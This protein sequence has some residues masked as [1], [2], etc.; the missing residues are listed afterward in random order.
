VT[1]GNVKGGNVNMGGEKGGKVL[2][3]A[4]DGGEV[5][6]VKGR[7]VGELVSCGGGV[8]GTFVGLGV[9]GSSLEKAGGRS[10]E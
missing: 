7:R 2:I 9:G 4:A 1:G 6:S 5:G 3:G 10:L 8:T